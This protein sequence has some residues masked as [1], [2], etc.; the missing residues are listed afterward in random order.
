MEDSTYNL[1]FH[2][3][4]AEGFDTGTVKKN[5]AILFNAPDKKVERL[6]SGNPVTV[7]KNIDR[8]TAL[9]YQAA[10][11]KAG[12]L[13][14][15]EP[16]QIQNAQPPETAYHREQ[17]PVEPETEAPAA[18]ADGEYP[19]PSDLQVISPQRMRRELRFSP[20]TAPSIVSA[21]NDLNFSRADISRIS[22]SEIE[23]VSVFSEEE[24]DEI[25]FRIV[26]FLKE[27]ERP[28]LLNVDTIR[29]N[30]F[31][32][33]RRNTTMNSLRNFILYLIHQNP[34]I[35]IDNR[36]EEFL[37][38]N[39]QNLLTVEPLDFITSLGVSLGK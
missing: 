2:G 13:C 3:V 8:N 20:M 9:K 16:A 32:N 26:F 12:A 29:Y 24:N 35:K 11:K 18:P 38:G 1:V 27:T 15:I 4:I 28:L 37:H 19:I 36:T 21:G 10:F 31:P 7:R 25:V 17:P 33:V 30:Q 6:F 39:E 14:T 23:L 22:I 5:I 34:H